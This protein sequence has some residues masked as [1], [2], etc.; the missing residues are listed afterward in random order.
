MVERR[1]EGIQGRKHWVVT[2]NF[3]VQ[4][5]KLI[6]AGHAGQTGKEEKENVY[7]LLIEAAASGPSASGLGISTQY[8]QNEQLYFPDSSLLWLKR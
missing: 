6:I 3:Y 8:W 2:S 5:K 4:E 1:Q 7:C